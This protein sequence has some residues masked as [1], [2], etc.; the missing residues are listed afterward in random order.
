VRNG[1]DEV[2]RFRGRD[3]WGSGGG[4][5]TLNNYTS[6]ILTYLFDPS[7]PYGLNWTHIDPSCPYIYG[8]TCSEQY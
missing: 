5:D 4:Q 7:N 1:T 3:G 2:R 6:F 8:E